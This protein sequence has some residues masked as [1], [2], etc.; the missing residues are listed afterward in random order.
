MLLTEK[1]GDCGGDTEVDTG[2]KLV[3]EE[4]EIMDFLEVARDRRGL[5]PSGASP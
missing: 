4:E 1:L 5:L 2:A 3:E